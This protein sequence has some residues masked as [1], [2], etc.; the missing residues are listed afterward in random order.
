MTV[1]AVALRELADV[2]LGVKTFLNPFFYV[3]DA[4]ISQF[5]IETRF[6]EP[7]FRAN[8]AKKDRVLQN[9]GR[10][11]SQIFRCSTTLDKLTGT[12]AAKYIRWAESQRHPGRRGQPGVLWKETPA[13][14]PAERVWYQNQAMPPPA[15][16]VVLKL[17][18][19]QLAPYIL[20]KKIRVDQSYNQVAAKPNVDE[21]LLVAALCS[22]WFAMAMETLGRTS[23]GQG[24]L[25]VP[26][27]DLRQLPV[28]DV[29]A[30]SKN[31]ATSW[32]SAASALLRKRR[33]TTAELRTSKEQSALDLVVMKSL[34]V[35][36]S[37]LHELYDGI[38]HLADTRRHLATA[39]GSIQRERYVTDLDAVAKDIATQLRAS[40]R[41]RFPK[42]FVLPGAATTPVQL[43][44][45]P[46]ELSSELMLGQRRVI[47]L[48]AGTVVWDSALPQH[49]G[50]VFIRA[51][52]L[53]QRDFDL[54]TEDDTADGALKKLE[55]LV[56][57]LEAQVTRLTSAASPAAQSELRRRVEIELSFP[58]TLLESPLAA[59]FISEH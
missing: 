48:A 17:L 46:I 50:E 27:E 49:V 45:L 41:D 53:G 18:N 35:R 36:G 26:T 56:K 57:E 40:V 54:P 22:G 9:V 43:G 2:H 34:G 31:E 4:R 39:R 30:L 25:Q 10:T 32:K 59:V 23:M 33:L 8:D 47:V 21:D 37:R 38:E 24:G 12:G 6:L 58:L 51:V 42:D 52:Q 16:I 55:T 28:P 1:G 14:R 29:R 7:V 15:R 5:G 13:V 3:D 20:S 19:D 44:D 11:K